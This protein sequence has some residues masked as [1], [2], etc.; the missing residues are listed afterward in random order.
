M[1]IFVPLVAVGF[2]LLQ[3]ILALIP[4]YDV[5]NPTLNSVSGWSA[6]S[7]QIAAFL[8][9]WDLFMPVGIVLAA[10]LAV[11]GAKVFVGV[12]HLI[13]FLY[14]RLPFKSS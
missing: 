13:Q 4:E 1:V 6:A 2:L 3:V 11:L 10:L 14:D 9:T 12:V 7:D 5:W 8:A